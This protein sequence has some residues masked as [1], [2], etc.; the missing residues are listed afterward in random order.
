MNPFTNIHPL[1]IVCYYTGTLALLIWLGHPGLYMLLIVMML[2]D[3]GMAVGIKRILKTFVCSIGAAA[4]CVVI[5]P[6]FNHRGVTLLFFFGDMRITKEAVLYGLYMALL[7]LGTL[8]LFFNFSNAMTS[9]K[10]MTLAAKRFPSLALLFSMILRIVPKV[11]NDF[12]QMK[13]LHGNCPRVWSALIGK[14]MEDSVERSMAM[15]SKG[16]GKTHRTS[17]FLR[18]LQAYDIGMIVSV[19]VMAGYVFVRQHD[20][21]VRVQFFPSIHV[22]WYDSIF[23]LLWFI[24]LG[25]PIWMRGKEEFLWFLSKRKTINSTTRS[26]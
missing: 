22:E 10:I 3:Y 12:K 7:L 2:A 16:Y 13:A 24:Y 18:S 9:E 17:C 8:L 4:V 21:P 11:K 5:N 1:A 25:I 15:K 14:M 23:W 20:S 19:F 6:L 26:R